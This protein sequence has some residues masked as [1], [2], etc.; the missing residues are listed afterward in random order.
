[1]NP[2]DHQHAIFFLD[3]TQGLAY[4]TVDRSGNLTRLQRASK[5]PASQTAAAATM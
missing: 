3:F 1:M 5:V 4:K 2:L